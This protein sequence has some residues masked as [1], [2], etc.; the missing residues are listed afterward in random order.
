MS[1]LHEGKKSRVRVKSRG[2]KFADKITCFILSD[3]LIVY[4]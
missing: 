3:G 2:S 4:M 1:R